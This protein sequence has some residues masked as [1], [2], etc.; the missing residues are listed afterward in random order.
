MELLGTNVAAAICPFTDEDWFATHRDIYG[1]GG[2]HTVSTLLE[3]DNIPGERRKDGMTCAVEETGWVYKLLNNAW[4]EYVVTSASV[5][6]ILTGTAD[7]PLFD[8]DVHTG[9]LY[10]KYVVGA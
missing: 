5:T 3:R 2:H 4:T 8:P 1:Q 10:F 9:V 7:V 6:K